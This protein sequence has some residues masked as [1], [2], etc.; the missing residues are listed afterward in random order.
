MYFTC[1]FVFIHVHT[2]V[3]MY[4]MMHPLC[5]CVHVHVCVMLPRQR[6]AS[7]EVAIGHQ[8]QAFRTEVAQSHSMEYAHIILIMHVCVLVSCVHEIQERTK[9]T[10][11]VYI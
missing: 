7:H 9:G 8:T 2:C 1:V 6:L 11:T 4:I 10:I 5:K 3:Y